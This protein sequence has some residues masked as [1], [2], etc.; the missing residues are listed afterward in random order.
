[1]KRRRTCASLLAIVVLAGCSGD[2]G[3]QSSSRTSTAASTTSRLPVEGSVEAGFARDMSVHHAQAVAM[4]EA[5][6][7]RTAIVNGQQAEIARMTD[8]LAKRGATS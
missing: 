1:M 5:I 8:M 7:D 3:T 6:R 2:A 4:A